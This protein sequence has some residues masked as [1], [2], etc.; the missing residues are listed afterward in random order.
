MDNK[1][2]SASIYEAALIFNDFNKDDKYNEVYKVFNNLYKES[3][4]ISLIK[5]NKL[6]SISY[7]NDNLNNKNFVDDIL[8]KIEITLEYGP[9]NEID[10]LTYCY[11]DKCPV[12]TSKQVV[13]EMLGNDYN[14]YW[15]L[16]VKL[17]KIQK[18]LEKI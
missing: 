8:N 13:N 10:N 2:L 11:Y 15:K 3:T 18:E 17:K 12:V 4:I 1:K 9:L 6:K 7:I 16:F 5:N 14:K